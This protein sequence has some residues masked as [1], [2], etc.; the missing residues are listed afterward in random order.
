MP[1]R[2]IDRSAYRYGDLLSIAPPI[3]IAKNAQ[4]GFDTWQQDTFADPISAMAFSAGDG[5]E[6]LES[7]GMFV[8]LTED[9]HADDEA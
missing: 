8:A 4:G 6:R 2:S 9:Q 3:T 5:F 7:T 1:R